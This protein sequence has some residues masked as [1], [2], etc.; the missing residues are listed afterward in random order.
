MSSIT[1]KDIIY[2]IIEFTDNGG[3]V[4]DFYAQFEN[5]PT[6]LKVGDVFVVHPNTWQEEKVEIMYVDEFVALGR[7][8]KGI[9]ISFYKGESTIYSNKGHRIGWKYNDSRY[10]YRLQVQAWK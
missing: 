10:N 6:S 2:S 3:T 5:T 8:I 4:K 7:V 1:K 9:S